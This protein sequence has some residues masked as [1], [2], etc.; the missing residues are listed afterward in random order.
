MPR[1]GYTTVRVLLWF[2]RGQVRVVFRTLLMELYS[3]SYSSMVGVPMW[4]LTTECLA[5]TACRTRYDHYEFTVVL[6]GL[7]NAPAAVVDRLDWKF[8]P[9]VDRFI[10]VFLMIP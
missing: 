3:G 10:V 9:S 4:N 8:R 1:R 6:F 5:K 7:T 2:E